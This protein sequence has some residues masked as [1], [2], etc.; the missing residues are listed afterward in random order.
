MHRWAWC[1]YGEHKGLKAKV[2]AI[3]PHVVFTHYVI[4]RVDLS[5]KALDNGF[6]SVLQ[7][8]IKI[9]NFIKASP[10]NTRLFAVLCQEMW[11][12]H[13]LLLLHTEIRWVLR[14]KVLLRLFEMRCCTPIPTGYAEC[15]TDPK[16]LS[17][18]AYFAELIDIINGLNMTL[19]GPNTN[20]VISRQS[21]GVCE[22]AGAL[23]S[24]RGVWRS[25]TGLHELEENELHLDE[26]TKAR[27]AH[28]LQGLI[29]Y[30]RRYF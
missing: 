15:L 2:Q 6:S 11:S 12:E 13:K 4:H 25:F 18:L 1:Y 8:A 27:I 19:Q 16:W 10:M 20:I 17:N 22:E 24:A 9:V 30:F 26:A 21:W 23:G 7:T 5:S 3:A 29:G 14:G 28:H